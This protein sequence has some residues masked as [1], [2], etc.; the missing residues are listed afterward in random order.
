[1]STCTGKS[2]NVMKPAK[3]QRSASLPSPNLGSQSSSLA[4]RIRTWLSWR[5]GSDLK[6]SFVANSRALSRSLVRS[7]TFSTCDRVVEETDQQIREEEDEF[8]DKPLARNKFPDNGRARESVAASVCTDDICVGKSS[9]YGEKSHIKQKSWQYCGRKIPKILDMFLQQE[10][11]SL[12]GFSSKAPQHAHCVDCYPSTWQD[13]LRLESSHTC[14]STASM[15]G[16]CA[17]PSTNGGRRPMSR[18]DV[19]ACRCSSWQEIDA[20]IWLPS[21]FLIFPL[22]SYSASQKADISQLFPYAAWVLLQLWRAAGG[23]ADTASPVRFFA[24]RIARKH[25]YANCSHSVN[26]RIDQPVQKVSI[27]DFPSAPLLIVALSF[28]R[29]GKL[30]RVAGVCCGN[31]R[32]LEESYCHMF[33]LER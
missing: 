9:G 3:L 32:L 2:A 13:I 14:F 21:A 26:N 29:N 30:V 31:K 12:L 1:M 6:N 4:S 27:S 25:I 5:A 33:Q 19:C 17:N 24:T 10:V 20:A 8:D 16:W 18:K 7:A 15:D 23:N 28:N 22:N 11:L